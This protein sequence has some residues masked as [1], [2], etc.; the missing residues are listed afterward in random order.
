MKSKQA[1]VTADDAYWLLKKQEIKA[2]ETHMRT[3]T[4]KYYTMIEHLNAEI[5]ELQSKRVAIEG[6]KRDAKEKIDCYKGKDRLIREAETRIESERQELKRY[7]ERQAE[8]IREKQARI[9]EIKG[10]ITREEQ[11]HMMITQK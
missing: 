1:Q 3:D 6:A 10:K 2:K 4:D 7:Q 5:N 9:E 8:E 11:R